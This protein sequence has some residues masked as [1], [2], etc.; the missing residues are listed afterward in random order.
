MTISKPTID[1]G[2]YQE[3]DKIKASIN[4]IDANITKAKKQLS[5]LD[6][7][8]HCYA[9]KQPIDNSKSKE[10]V[11]QLTSEISALT[12]DRKE[13]EKSL[14]KI[15]TTIND[16]NSALKIY[17]VNQQRIDRFS[18]LSQLIDNSLPTEYPNYTGISKQTPTT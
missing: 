14:S 10:L 12:T 13:C 17:T 3:Q 4:K 6:T 16:Y 1:E 5:S 8:D 15:S 9:C 7:S 11:E 2:I 18:Q